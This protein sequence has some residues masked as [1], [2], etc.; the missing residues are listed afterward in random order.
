MGSV[1]RTIPNPWDSF[2]NGWIQVVNS[3]GG[4][5]P[6]LDGPNGPNPSV[7]GH[8]TFFGAYG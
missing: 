8:L 1:D 5:S 2:W 6:L 7:L 4:E 3:E